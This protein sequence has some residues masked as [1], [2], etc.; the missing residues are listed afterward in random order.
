LP[1]S[2]AC[3]LVVEVLEIVEMNRIKLDTLSGKP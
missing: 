1:K 3:I 2:Q